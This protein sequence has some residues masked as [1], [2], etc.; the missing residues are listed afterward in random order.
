MG[1]HKFIILA[2]DTLILGV[3]D[4]H[5]LYLIGEDCKEEDKLYGA[6]TNFTYTIPI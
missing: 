6:Q 1:F 3:E 2:R 5:N 4:K